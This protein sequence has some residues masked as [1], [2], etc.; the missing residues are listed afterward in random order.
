MGDVNIF[1]L[2]ITL[3][4]VY[5]IYTAV[6]MKKSGKITGGVIV[7]KDVEVDKIKDKDGFIKYMYGK[8]LLLGILTC[9]VG[10]VGI[11]NNK[12]HGPVIISFIGV[13]CYL[14]MLVLFAAATVK[15]KKRYMEQD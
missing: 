12:L 11:V 2:L 13:I 1:D 7:S 15:A 10:A 5:L 6:I 14:V 3:S 9:I 4:G 8:V